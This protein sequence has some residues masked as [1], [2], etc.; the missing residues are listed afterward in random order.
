M[1][2]L[3]IEFLD[4]NKDSIHRKYQWL[5]CRK[6]LTM[7]LNISEDVLLTERVKQTIDGKA[8]AGGEVEGY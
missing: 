6:I 4:N 2:L 5:D 8:N 7:D 1:A 3:L